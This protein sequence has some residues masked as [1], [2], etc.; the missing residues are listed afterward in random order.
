MQSSRERIDSLTGVR[1][2]AACGV[3]L[4]HFREIT[5]T[6]VWHFPVF[7][8]LIANGAYGVDMFFVLSGFIL[9]HV[10]MDAFCNGLSADKVRQFLIYRLARI[11]PVH[12]V[13]FAVML[14]LLA[15]KLMISGSGDLP[16]RYDAVTITSTL[17]L[18]H[19][20]IPGVQTPNMPAWSISAEWFAYILF[21]ALCFFLSYGKWTPAFYAAIGLSLAVF[22]PFGHYPLS[23][24]MSGFLVGM[25]ACRI[26]PA[27]R[28]IKIGR[29]AG[30]GVA[31]AVL[32]WAQAPTP[33]V[34]IGLV[35]FALLI[36]TLADARDL[37]SRLLSLSAVVYL[38]E[39]SYS[40][41]MVH[42]PVR[43][44]VR[45]AFQM[46]GLLDTLPPAL[47]VCAFVSVTLVGAVVSY[48]FVEL[49]GRAFLRR[50]L[51]RVPGF[52]AVSTVATGPR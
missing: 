21:P 34:E 30:L 48:H 33:R 16:E 52:A 13:T 39:I 25:A 43:V 8:K 23:H 10:Y 38:G 46:L 14:A 50:V 44:I 2:I 1:G 36:L 22:E 19:A 24:V 51:T 40:I 49:P 45:N 27:A 3:M 29:F 41:Y 6:R 11:Y 4:M 35:L 37:L 18:L 5:P 32:Y 9:Y 17:A 26:M 15:A 42:W 28:Q 20:W 47:I 12:L 7:D 31:A